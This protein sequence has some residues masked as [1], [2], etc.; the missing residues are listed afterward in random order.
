MKPLLGLA[1]SKQNGSRWEARG[2]VLITEAAQLLFL[3]T[4]LCKRAESVHT[5]AVCKRG[6]LSEREV[7]DDPGV[8]NYLS[9]CI[10]LLRPSALEEGKFKHCVDQQVCEADA[11]VAVSPRCHFE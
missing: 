6:K 7:S 4:A 11:G 2:D 1:L 10:L 8:S 9:V 5:I 3:S